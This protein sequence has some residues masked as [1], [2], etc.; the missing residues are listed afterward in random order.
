[1]EKVYESEAVEARWRALWEKHGL[2]I[3]DAASELEPFTMVIP[4]PN[5]T[6][7]LHVG[8]AL[9]TTI[10]DILARYKR[11][12]GFSVLWLPGIDHAGIATQNVVERAL[13]KDGIDRHKLGREVFLEK[14]WEWKEQYGSTILNQQKRLGAS[15][16]WSRLRFTMDEGLSKAVREVFT[17]LY[18]EGL[19]YRGNYIVNWCPRCHTALSDIEVQFEETDGKLYYMVYPI[20]DADVSEGGV[21]SLNVATTRPETMLGDTAVAV[22]PTDE[23]YKDLI[24]KRIKLPLTGREIPIVGDEHVSAEFGTGAVKITPAH[25]FNDFEVAGRHSLE[26][27]NI[28][29]INA[30]LNSNAHKYEGLDR[31]AARKKIIEELEE[32]GLL[33]G[34]EAHK[35]MIGECYRCSTI[36]EPRLSK[37]WFVKVAP[38]A[39]PAIEAVEDGSISFV[40]KSWEKTYFE[41]MRNIRDWCISR[42]IWWGHRI[43]AWHCE[44]CQFITLPSG[45][46]DPVLCD[47]CGSDKITQDSDVLD[48]WFSSALWPFSTLGWP[49]Q[50]EDLAKYYPTSVLSTSFDI[51]FF[52]VARMIM[53]GKKFKGEVPFKEVYIHALIRDFEGKKMSKSKGNVIDP[54]IM[55][56]EYGTDALR[57]TLAAFAAQGRDIKLA[58]ERIAGYRNFCNK[59][60][61]LARFTL[62]N[63]DEGSEEAGTEVDGRSLADKWILTKLE[64]CRNDVETSIDRYQF[65][66]AAKALYSFVWHELCDWY[67][68]LIKPDLWGDNGEERKRHSAGVLLIVLRDTLKL[69][70]PIMPFI[71]EEIYSNLPVEK[72]GRALHEERFPVGLGTW[73]EEEAELDTIM[74]VIRAIRNLRT[75]NNVKPGVSIESTCQTDGADVRDTLQRGSEYIQR[76]AKVSSVSVEPA[77]AP[78]EDSV[79]FVITGGPVVSMQLKGLIDVDAEARKIEGEIAKEQAERAVIEGKLANGSFVGKAPTVVVEKVRAR[80]VE[81]NEKIE[82]LE[83]G[84]ERIRG[85]AK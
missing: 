78:P 63:V 51:I 9:N 40:P 83:D 12:K 81:V 10:Q 20:V 50:T 55:M 37:Q 34:V 52:W 4:P 48:T 59:L 77:G 43:P 57:F 14:V 13:A 2:G 3:A 61:N 56:E 42:Q 36:V 69:L 71:T 1:M 73:P 27:I 65:D 32:L 72:S 66:A 39:G 30:V 70:H 18:S 82:K 85:M 47:G 23:R 74:E 58:E 8:H 29:D 22:N 54:L 28:F 6:G 68:E 44:E 75:E 49:E 21:T 41:W 17:T 24:G 35:M 33:E 19:I 60:W 62:M 67:V 53:M 84:L 15:C 64:K 38:L 76:I 11:M 26:S 7:A 46:T 80:L 45:A 79:S 16:D 31:F 5:I 25:D